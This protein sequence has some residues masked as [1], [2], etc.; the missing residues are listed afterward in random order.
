VS[1]TW[2]LSLQLFYSVFKLCGCIAVTYP[3]SS[4][5]L[6]V[7][8]D[9]RLS[10]GCPRCVVD[11]LVATCSMWWQLKSHVSHQPRAIMLR[12]YNDIVFRALSAEIS[13]L[14]SACLSSAQ[15]SSSHQPLACLLWEVV[16]ALV[17]TRCT[18]LHLVI[19]WLVLHLSVKESLHS[20]A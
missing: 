13:T 1:G 8:T 3:S 4:A 16:T 9:C 15:M 20:A 6:C 19:H 7:T 11:D 10:S 18:M 12:H 5:P 2:S 14:Q 17:S